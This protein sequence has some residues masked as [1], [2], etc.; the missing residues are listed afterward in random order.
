M[1][2]GAGLVMMGT[3][4]GGTGTTPPATALGNVFCPTWLRSGFVP[5]AGRGP[6][7]VPGGATPCSVRVLCS[8]CGEPTVPVKNG[9]SSGIDPSGRAA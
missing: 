5:A 7:A 4:G 3:A 2:G 8:P 1:F 6:A 9:S